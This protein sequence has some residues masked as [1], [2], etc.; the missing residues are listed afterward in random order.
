MKRKMALAFLTALFVLG[1]C[2]CGTGGSSA[3]P[4][5]SGSTGSAQAAET[6]RVYCFAAGKADAILLTTPHSAVLIDTGESGFGKE[7]VSWLK[8]QGISS[9]DALILTHFDQDHVGGSAKVLKSVPVERVLQSDCPKDSSEYAAYL[10]ALDAAGL[11]AQTVRQTVSFSLD[12][13]SYTVDPPRQAD[14]AV[15]SSNNSSLIVSAAYGERR[16][17]F[18]GDAEDDRL[19]EFLEEHPGTY[20]FLKVP[21]HGHWQEILPEFLQTVQPAYAVITCSDKE[22]EDSETVSALTDAGT[23][24]FLTRKGPVLAESDGT[25]LRV[26]YDL[27]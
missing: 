24:V 13:V 18:A 7:I 22:P 27:S 14:Y 19:R 26:Q 8:A 5:P 2:G 17:L 20:D 9:L 16:F 15:D 3:S 1:L 11:T 6:L 12:G 21:Y 10:S 23:Q 25:S 4:L